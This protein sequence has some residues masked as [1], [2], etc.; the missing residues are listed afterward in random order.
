MA[1]GIN[2]TG[3]L[4]RY[5]LDHIKFQLTIRVFSSTFL[6]S[7]IEDF[8]N[9]LQ[10]SKLGWTGVPSLPKIPSDH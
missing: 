5:V 7:V 1:D 8:L 10:G 3:D 2:Y 9:T 6:K 4:A